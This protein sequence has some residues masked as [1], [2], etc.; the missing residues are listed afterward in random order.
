MQVSQVFV[1]HYNKP[2]SSWSLCRQVRSLWHLARL[3]MVQMSQV[4]VTPYNKPDSS[5]SWYSWVRSLWYLTINLTAANYCASK[6]GLLTPYNK[7]D[8]NWSWCSWDRSLWHLTVANYCAGKWY[9]LWHLTIK[10]AGVRSLCRLVAELSSFPGLESPGAYSVFS[11]QKFFL[12]LLIF[13]LTVWLLEISL[14][15]QHEHEQHI[16]LC[17][18]N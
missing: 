14:C 16:E 17:L 15:T 8:S 11:C 18:L 5:W 3:V 4:F 6:S 13:C 12:L 9:L 1:T 7:P 2:D 10:L